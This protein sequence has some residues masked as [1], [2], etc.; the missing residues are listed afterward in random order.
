MLK[1]ETFPAICAHRGL[2]A[3]CPENSLPAFGA[4]VALG[5]HELELDVR[6]TKDKELVVSHDENLDR[7]SDGTGLVSEH[8]LAELRRCNIGKEH[9]WQVYFCTP[10]EVFSA[11]GNKI[12]LNLHLKEAG[13]DGVLIRKL[14]TL[15]ERYDLKD[16]VY[17]A[18]H[19]P[20]VFDWIDRLAPDIQKTAIQLP[21]AADVKTLAL[22]HQCT[23]VQFWRGMYEKNLIEDLHRHKI[24]CN[25]FY[26]DDAKDMAEQLSM[27]IDV[28]LTNRADIAVNYFKSIGG[29]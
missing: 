1:K 8:T 6:L 9:G 20:C 27:G 25:L 17:L 22:L 15:I 14:Y 28:L 2:S 21:D 18:T 16:S 19:D 5:A 12:I 4:A 3:L 11:F 26:S 23:R 13:E 7:I 24:R 10:E 29:K